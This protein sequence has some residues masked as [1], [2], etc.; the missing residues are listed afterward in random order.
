MGVLSAL[1]R[2]TQG[3]GK[4]PSALLNW[5]QDLQPVPSRASH[6]PPGEATSGMTRTSSRSPHGPGGNSELE[7]K[8]LAAARR[9]LMARHYAPRTEK[10]YVSWIRRF[11]RH[12]PGRDP[13]DMGPEEVNAFL[14]SLAVERSVS[15][16]T[17][18]QAAA[19]LLFLYRDGYK[20]DLAGLD[21]IIRAKHSRTLPVVLNRTEVRAVLEKME[22]VPKTVA[23]LLYGSGLRLGEALKLRVKDVDLER[24]ELVIRGP[25]GNRDRV[26][27]LPKSLITQLETRME[28]SALV[29]ALDRRRGANGVSLPEG[30]RRKYPGA[31]L[32]LAWQWLFP[33]ARYTSAPESN[34]S[35][36]YPMHHTRVQRAFREAVRQAK[37]AKKATCHSLRHSF[38]THLLEDGYDIR[39]I[40]ELLGHRSVRATM[41]YTHVLNSGGLAV[42]SPLDRLP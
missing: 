39:T 26:T 11:M 40:Q 36:R 21:Q 27:M 13:G 3:L 25:K 34:E 2:I 33:G 1:D 18:N 10:T 8:V 14:S 22:G 30:L 42:R 31:P 5:G 20:K 41:I 9:L 28:N 37:I 23:L 7:R 4:N 38:A 32:E 17:Q 6:A 24:C 16:S 35:F 15:A 19:A 12:Y 29:L